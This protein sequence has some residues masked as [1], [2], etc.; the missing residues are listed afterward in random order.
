MGWH[1]VFWAPVFEKSTDRCKM[2]VNGALEG[3][4]QWD[5]GKEVGSS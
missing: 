5:E 2:R 4:R 1:A 3:H